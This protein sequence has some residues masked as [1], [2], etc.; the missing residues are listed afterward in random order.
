MFVDLQKSSLIIYLKLALD[1]KINSYKAIYLLP[2][3]PILIIV[4]RHF[5]DII[6]IRIILIV[7]L[8]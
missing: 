5:Q 3:D 2:L 4:I 1:Y 8:T 6:L 7:Y